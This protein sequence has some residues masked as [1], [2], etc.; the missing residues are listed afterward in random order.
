MNAPTAAGILKGEGQTETL[1]RALG[2]LL[3]A[4]DVLALLGDLGSGKTTLTRGIAR[5]LGIDERYYITSPTF[6]L[7]NEYPGTLTLYHVDLYRLRGGL[8][9]ME[10]GLDDCFESGGV[11]VVEWAE[12]LSETALPE[13][14]VRIRIDIVDETDRRFEMH[15]VGPA[16]AERLRSWLENEEIRALLG[17]SAS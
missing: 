6:T 3:R 14:A 1:G 2:A 9:T 16:G 4:G 7:V 12:R 5:G 13:I 17:A 8:D 11:A 15:P 10:L